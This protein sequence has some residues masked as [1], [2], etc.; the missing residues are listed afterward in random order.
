MKKHNVFFVLFALVVS[1]QL[2]AQDSISVKTLDKVILY[3]IGYNKVPDHCNVPLIGFINVAKGNHTGL[4]LGFTNNTADN[5]K[6]LAVGFANKVGNN[7]NGGQIGFFN[8]DG[9]SSNGL[10]VGFFNTI[11]DKGTGAQI[12]FFNTLGDSF[13]G[14]HVGFFNTLGNSANG[15]QIGF[16]NTL[17]D[18]YQGLQVGFFNTLGNKADGMQVGF[19]N[20]LGNTFRGLQVGFIN[21]VGNK[22]EGLEVGFLNT[23]PKLA[24]L[25]IGFINRVDTVE[26]GIPVGFLSF[27]KKGGYQALEVGVSEMFPVNISYK[28]G[29]KQFYTSLVVS[30]SPISHNHYAIGLGIGTLIPINEKLSFNPEFIS[31]TTCTVLWDQIYNLHL[32]LNYKL[33]D[34]FSIVAG[35]SLVWNHLN[36]GTIFH[37]PSFSFYNTELNS[38]SKLLIGLN[39]AVRYQFGK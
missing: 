5:F 6:G 36:D 9:N 30:Y 4:Q 22:L 31:Q 8:S 24:G 28:T 21:T 11:G 26:K 15:V 37:K 18:S 32:N 2:Q 19:F 20:T 13:H 35:P 23:T 34:R 29:I 33:S 17:G 12:G 38:K 16:F 7:I 39:A 25:Q 1:S 3:T 14:L 10:T 27:V